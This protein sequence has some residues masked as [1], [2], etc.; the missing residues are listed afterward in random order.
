[1]LGRK[2]EEDKESNDIDT[3]FKLNIK[4]SATV[5]DGKKLIGASGAPLPRL[6]TLKMKKNDVDY[7]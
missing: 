1:M 2:N 4:R 6:P 5:K 7:N 3:K